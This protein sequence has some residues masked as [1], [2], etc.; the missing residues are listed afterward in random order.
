LSNLSGSDHINF[1]L[2]IHCTALRG[3]SIFNFL[4]R[5]LSLW[6]EQDAKLHEKLRIPKQVSENHP[7]HLVWI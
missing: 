4:Y 1:L 2:C 3:S 7:N 6:P 5:R